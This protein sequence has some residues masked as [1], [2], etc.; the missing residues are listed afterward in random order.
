MLV[1]GVYSIEMRDSNSRFNK[2]ELHIHGFM[3]KVLEVE[4]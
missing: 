2:K 1:I 4:R 3:E